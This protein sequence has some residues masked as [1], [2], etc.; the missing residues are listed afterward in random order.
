[1]SQ[2]TRDHGSV[3][4]GYIVGSG[5]G[6]PSID[7]IV[8]EE[9]KI[10]RDHYG[11]PVTIRFNSDM[12]SGGAWLLEPVRGTIFLSSSSIGLGVVLSNSKL[13]AMSL[14]EQLSMPNA[15]YAALSRE[16]DTIRYTTAID[17]RKTENT[18]PADSKNTS[19]Y[20]LNYMVF[21][22]LQEAVDYLFSHAQGLRK[23]KR[24]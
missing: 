22:T 13:T 9:A 2:I 7:S 15:E 8:E 3:V 18:V 24:A 17:V 19:P 21:D 4:D 10:L 20:G 23:E 16:Y 1:M 12:R 5:H 11:S 6:L 14:E